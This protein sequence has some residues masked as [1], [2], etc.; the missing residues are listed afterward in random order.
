MYVCNHKNIYFLQWNVTSFRVNKR[1]CSLKIRHRKKVMKLHVWMSRTC[2]NRKTRMYL[3]KKLYFFLIWVC[4]ALAYKTIKKKVSH[5]S[6]IEITHLFPALI[7]FLLQRFSN[8]RA[9]S[10]STHFG[11]CLITDITY[12]SI[13]MNREKT[14]SFSLAKLFLFFQLLSTNSLDNLSVHNSSQ[15]EAR[16]SMKSFFFP[17]RV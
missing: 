5:F 17:Y 11:R 7:T 12:W 1:S 3:H 4:S 15:M 8:F 6:I 9:F 14:N 13:T 2:R 16:K 10:L